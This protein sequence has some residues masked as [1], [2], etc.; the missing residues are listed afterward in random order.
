[1]GI[2]DPATVIEEQGG[3]L[4]GGAASG[5]QLENDPHRRRTEIPFIKTAIVGVPAP[6]IAQHDQIEGN[7]LLSLQIENRLPLELG[8]DTPRLGFRNAGP[9][10]VPFSFDVDAGV[11]FRRPRPPFVPQRHEMALQINNLCR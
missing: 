3:Y 5:G 9:L 8:I 2:F 4:L 1:M 7:K 6:A 10:S 11:G